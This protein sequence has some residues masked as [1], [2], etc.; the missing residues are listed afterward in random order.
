MSRIGA[1]AR[2]ALRHARPAD[3][4]TGPATGGFDR[5]YDGL[6]YGWLACPACGTPP[7]LLPDLLIDGQRVDA[8][9][10][11][12][13]RPDVPGGRG[14]VLR[15]PPTG[16]ATPRVRVQCPAHPVHGLEIQADLEAWAVG[17]LGAIE[18]STWPMVTGWLAVLNPTAANDIALVIGGYGSL[19]V[20]GPVSRPDVAAYLGAPGV[21]GFQVDLG[22]S[23][24]ASIGPPERIAL[25]D[26]TPLRLTANDGVL[27]RA[28][29]QDS[30]LGPDEPGCLAGTGGPS[31]D[32]DEQELA[33]LR[34]RFLETGI[35]PD[36]DWREL[37]TGLGLEDH[38]AETAQW[39][40]YL[41]DHGYA[42]AE[43]VG[44]LTIRATQRLAASAVNPLPLSLAGIPDGDKEAPPPLADWTESV[45]G[46]HYE[47]CPFTLPQP[48]PPVP[49]QV[50][51]VLV[52]GLVHHRSGLGQNARN[53]LRALELAGI[54]GCAAPFFPAPGGWNPRLRVYSDAARCLDDHAV[55]LHLPIDRVI[56]SLSAQPALMRTDRLIGYFMWETEVIPRQFHRALDI[57]DEI[58]T[59]TNFVADAFRKV[60]DT[61]VHVTGN[62]VDIGDVAP[63]TRASLGIAEDAFVV[64]YAFDANSTVARKNPNGAIEAF[65]R[66][67]RGDPSAVLLLKVRN[68]QQVH[69]L[70]RVGDPHAR[71][72]VQRLDDDP[73]IR[74]ITG[75]H[76][77]AYTLGLIALA[78]CYLS[79]HRSEG[80]GYGISE[81]I[82]LGKAVIATDY[83]GSTDF[84]TEQSARLVGYDLRRITPGEYF[85]WESGMVWAD[86]DIH[87]AASLLQS[88]RAG[89]T[90]DRESAR[91]H[92]DRVA[93]IQSLSHRYASLLR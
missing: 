80:Y 85:Y 29:V 75:E 23:L 88:V 60:T 17:V 77:H 46:V 42:T 66:A 67:F 74:V 6:V 63:V 68:M 93:S 16:T 22:T 64:H 69:A 55:L 48:A 90:P 9:V 8:T 83:S 82:A 72:L 2:R 87:S 47:S 84:A 19:P 21:G 54:H 51:R 45:W 71:D 62:V 73:A 14:F 91:T 52:A 43:I 24:G 40:D 26:G 44:W 78:D 28:Q 53:S 39:A 50:D 58:W 5:V 7:T 86:P 4:G 32:L 18:T 37:L 33:N 12:T 31:A 1:R 92:A 15:F 61:P 34:R 57:V 49:N 20:S 13:P 3:R 35:D 38:S 59:A 70:A 36:G 30:P 10:A 76:D 25:P 56:P 41:A 81:A 79:L 89:S 27:S 11:A 65:H